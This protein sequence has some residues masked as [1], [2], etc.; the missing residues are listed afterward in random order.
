[1]SI[2][3]CW[4]NIF[5]WNL[6]RHRIII[7]RWR[8]ANWKHVIWALRVCTHWMRYSLDSSISYNPD[9]YKFEAGLHWEMWGWIDPKHSLLLQLWKENANLQVRREARRRTCSP[10]SIASGNEEYARKKRFYNEIRYLIIRA[11]NL[12]SGWRLHKHK[13]LKMTIEDQ[14]TEKDLSII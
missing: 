14:T 5:Y 8:V 10:L 11:M 4:T 12:I 6:P 2:K 1:M 3:R 7:R 13:H 9:K